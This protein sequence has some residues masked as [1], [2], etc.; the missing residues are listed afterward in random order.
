MPTLAAR[1]AAARLSQTEL[2]ARSRVSVSTI[3]RIE[4][5]GT[6]PCPRAIAQLSAALGT[7]PEA[8]EEFQPAMLGTRLPRPAVRPVLK[9]VLVLDGGHVLLDVFRD[10]LEGEGFPVSI[11]PSLDCDV[12]AIAR[13]APDLIVLDCLY[14]VEDR[15]W[16][17]LC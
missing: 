17:F 10:I 13:L 5:G 2:A 8:I 14:Q 7:L 9:H 11:Q 16:P 4:H 1:R 6:R 12:D 3:T 15:G